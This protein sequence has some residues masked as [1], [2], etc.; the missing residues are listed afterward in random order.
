MEL[1]IQSR[2]NEQVKRLRRALSQGQRTPEG[3][4]GVDTFRLLEEALRSGLAVPQVFFTAEAEAELRG[5]LA[6]HRAEPQ[7]IR[8]PAKVLASVS[9]SPAA[10]G[11]AALVRPRSWT[12]AELFAPAP[13]LVVV[14]A[15]VQ[16][17]G[18]AG[19][20]LRTAEAFGATGALLL[21][22]TVHPENPKFLRASAGS[23]FRLPHHHGLK[24]GQ[25]LET[26]RRH[27]A[28][29]YAAAPRAR[30]TL[31]D[32]DFTRP[33]ALAIG[34]EASGVPEP[35]RAA[36]EAV[37]IPHTHRVESLNAAMAAGIFLYHAAGIRRA[38]RR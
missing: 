1:V 26:L 28:H 15:G 16:D 14:L 38:A 10:Q 8:L 18:N 30:R 22:G 33:L 7:M 35:I 9:E 27:G 6:R 3:L 17:P 31:N 34:A 2:Q 36:A 29:L 13:A 21:E 5:L 11:V 12:I 32:V 20:I 24:Y 4:L 19:T 23:A 37:A 25:A